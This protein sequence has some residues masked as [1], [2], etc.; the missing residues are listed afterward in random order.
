MDDGNEKKAGLKEKFI[1]EMKEMLAIFLYFALFF[2]TFTTYRRLVMHELGVSYFHYGFALLKALVLAKVVLLGQYARLS[3]IFD[4]R[5]LIVPT[6]YKVLVFGLFYLAFDVLEHFI[7]GVL[8]KEDLMDV[9][10]KI[11]GAGR[12]ELLART[13]V[14]LLAFLPF[15]AFGETGRVL[16][17]G[18][19]RDLFLRKRTEKSAAD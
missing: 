2:C 12:D 4:D 18:R 13:L 11:I 10:Q 15:F 5:P 3:K 16:G 6:L 9:F 17:E 8:H 7:E 1:R 19:L 14:V